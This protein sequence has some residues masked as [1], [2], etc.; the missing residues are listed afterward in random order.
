M[1]QDTKAFSG[2]AVAD[3]AAAKAFY[4]DTLGL[5]VTEDDGMLTLHLAGGRTRSSTRSRT[6]SRRRTR[7]STSRSTTSRPPSTSSPSGASSSRSTRA[8]IR[9]RRE[10]D[11]A[12]GRTAHRVVHR[13]GRQ[14]PLGHPTLTEPAQADANGSFYGQPG[15]WTAAGAVGSSRHGQ[16]SITNSLGPCRQDDPV[17]LALEL[18]VTYPCCPSP[19]RTWANVIRG[20][21]TARTRKLLPKPSVKSPV[22]GP[23]ACGSGMSGSNQR[24]QAVP[25]AG[26]VNCTGPSVN[27]SRRG[28]PGSRVLVA[29]EHERM[30][31]LDQAGSRGDAAPT[32]APLESKSRRGPPSGSV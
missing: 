9:D 29:G 6:T 2:F 28:G 16:H 23:A 5:D 25:A 24:C 20:L 27:V 1:F 11:H 30:C 22:F 19:A 32:G 3:V 14:R 12:Q 31:L 10:G 17:S 26:A 8:R 7:S 4:G 13:P 18:S 21:A 15:Y